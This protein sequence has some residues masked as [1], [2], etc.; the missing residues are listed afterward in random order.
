MNVH[1][2]EFISKQLAGKNA[3]YAGD[4][5]TSTPRK[6]GLVYIESSAESAAIADEFVAQLERR[7][8]RDRRNGSRTPSTRR[9]S[10]RP[11]RRSSRS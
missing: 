11:R 5:F 7:G 6:Y 1:A 2:T 4:E 3:E 10:R 8:D 9:R